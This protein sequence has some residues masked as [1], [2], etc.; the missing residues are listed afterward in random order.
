MNLGARMARDQPDDPFDL[1]GLVACPGVDP[2]LAQSVEPQHAIGIDH[3]LL[4][5]GVRERGGDGRP[6]RSAQHRTAS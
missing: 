6:H 2:T 3:D 4:S 5:R 1:R